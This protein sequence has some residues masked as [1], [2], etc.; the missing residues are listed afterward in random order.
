MKV[1]CNLCGKVFDLMSATS[2][3]TDEGG[4]LKTYHFCS[5]EHLAEFTKNRGMPLDKD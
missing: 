1:M 4:Q 5:E 3:A 2:F